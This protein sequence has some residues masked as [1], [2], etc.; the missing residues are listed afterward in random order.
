MKPMYENTE[1]VWPMRSP[2]EKRDSLGRNK[3]MDYIE[4]GIFKEKRL[5]N[6]GDKNP[7]LFAVVRK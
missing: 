7:T 3:A 4:D 6:I 1:W 5:C 2:E